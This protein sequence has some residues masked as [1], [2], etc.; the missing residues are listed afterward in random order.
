M[1]ISIHSKDM[2]IT[3]IY[4]VVQPFYLLTS[5]LQVSPVLQ[6]TTSD[7]IKPLTGS[8]TPV[9]T[10]GQ[11]ANGLPGLSSE[12]KS[13]KTLALFQ[14]ASMLVPVRPCYFEFLQI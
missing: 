9:S 4:S 13:T 14:V 12:K 11:H 10:G 1:V 7:R 3:I 2:V 6:Y 5:E 8:T